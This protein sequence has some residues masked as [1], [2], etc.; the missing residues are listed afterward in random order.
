MLPVTPLEL[1]PTVDFA[2]YVA[3]PGTRTQTRRIV[4][5]EADPERKVLAISLTMDP[6][7]VR[8]RMGDFDVTYPWGVIAQATNVPRDVKAI[9]K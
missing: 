2:Q 5:R 6:I 3:E 7:G 1:R 8:A 4:A 9:G